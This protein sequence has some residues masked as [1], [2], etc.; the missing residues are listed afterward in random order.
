MRY[1]VT[2]LFLVLISAAGMFA[3]GTPTLT[4]EFD[5][6]KSNATNLND[7]RPIYFKTRLIRKDSISARADLGFAGISDP[8]EVRVTPLI[9]IRD[10]DSKV[11][12]TIDTETS[13]LSTTGKSDAD[14]FQMPSITFFAESKVNAV[15][16]TLISGAKKLVMTLELLAE[17]E[18]AGLLTS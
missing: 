16:I 5:T 11:V 14:A 6:W 18:T 17:G 13:V 2:A 1:F 9:L 12:E 4:E 10:A 8:Y 15:R 7:Q 3:Q